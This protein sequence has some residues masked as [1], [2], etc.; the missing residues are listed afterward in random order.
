MNHINNENE[1][2]VR[3]NQEFVVN[4]SPHL[5]QIKT[6][7]LLSHLDA[8]EFVGGH[9]SFTCGRHRTRG[10]MHLWEEVHGALRFVA[11]HPGEGVKGFRHVDGAAL[12]ARQGALPLL[13][14]GLKAR[15]ARERG[16][17]HQTRRKLTNHI[18]AEADGREFRELGPHVLRNVLELK[19]AA[20]EAT[21]P[22]KT[23]G[24][25]VEGDELGFGR[26]FWVRG[27]EVHQGALERGEPGRAAVHVFLVHLV[28]HHHQPVGRGELE[29][30]LH[31]GLR[32]RLPCGVARVDHHDGAGLCPHRPVRHPDSVQAALQLCLRHAPSTV[33]V[34]IV[35][36]QGAVEHGG[37]GAVQWVLGHGHKHRIQGAANHERHERFHPRRGA[38]GEEHVVWVRSNPAVSRADKLRHMLPHQRNPL[39][40]AVG[41]C[42]GHCRQKIFRARRHVLGVER[43]HGR[44][45]EKGWVHDKAQGLPHESQR[46][47]PER[48]R[49]ADV[50]AHDARERH[51]L[52][53]LEVTLQLHGLVQEPTPHSVLGANDQR[54][55][56]ID[57]Q[58][59]LG[60]GNCNTAG[61]RQHTKDTHCCIGFA[62][63]WRVLSIL[64]GLLKQPCGRQK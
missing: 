42:R 30:A 11:S 24:G 12:Q 40:V 27:L 14:V 38:V 34:Q 9:A 23:L 22:D 1:N 3:H 45:L 57:G 7:I 15:L 60:N 35:R 43:Q 33:L 20:S 56:P 48:L 41:S 64:G 19:V 47:L 46:L 4:M 2:V 58:A 32:Q 39:G 6:A 49:V 53:R 29:N 54:V 37:G 17:H 31:R 36:S 62:I 55:D 8:V 44:L 18:G 21:L 61:R 5:K 51:R 10:E 16:L 50:T 26:E 13:L 28:G 59:E 25:G 63:K 52:A